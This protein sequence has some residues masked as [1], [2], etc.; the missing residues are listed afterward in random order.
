MILQSVSKSTILCY[1]MDS[2]QEIGDG[3]WQARKLTE[4]ENIYTMQQTNKYSLIHGYRKYEFHQG[5][6]LLNQTSN[7]SF[8]KKESTLSL[9]NR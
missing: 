3:R 1:E 7:Y 9:N 2:Q 4:G 8:R 5:E 6:K